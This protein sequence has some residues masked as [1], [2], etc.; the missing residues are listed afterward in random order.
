MPMGKEH[1]LRNDESNL[2][3]SRKTKIETSIINEDYLNLDKK[4]H[5]AIRVIAN[6]LYKKYKNRIGVITRFVQTVGR[7]IR[8][9][10][11]TTTNSID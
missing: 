5:H 2:F 8:W 9:A 6:S 1:R 4:E 3:K 11:I 7:S 10:Q